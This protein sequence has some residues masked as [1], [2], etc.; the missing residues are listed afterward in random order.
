MSAT[1]R[2]S[3][4]A[5]CVAGLLV[6]AIASCKEP[7]PDFD[8]RASGSSTD[9]DGDS[10]T[11]SMPP[12]TMAPM[13]TSI[14]PDGTTTL[15]VDGSSSGPGGTT[16][17]GSS[18]SGGDAVLYPP[19]MLDGDPACMRPYDD[20]YD[21]AAPQHSACTLPCSDDEDCP[22]PPTGNAPVECA[23][24]GNDQCLLDCSG[25][26]TCPDGMAC[27]AVGPAGMYQRC[28]WPS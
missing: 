11:S 28:L 14:D 3:G 7:N 20:C 12:T 16:E 21:F 27:V 4:G 8:G 5:G 1:S 6:L 25:D 2:V 15:P 23:G 13:T 18:S 17:T 19:C 24:Q 9:G 26:A 22:Q 10:G